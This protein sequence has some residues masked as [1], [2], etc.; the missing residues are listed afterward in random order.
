MSR[1][2]LIG[3]G[4]GS[5]L[6]LIGAACTPPQPNVGTSEIQELVAPNTEAG[7]V[8]NLELGQSATGRLAGTGESPDASYHTYTI[9][10]PA[11]TS[12]L[13]IRMDADDDL[14][15]GIKHGSPIEAYGENADWDLNDTSTNTFATLTV[16][17]PSA[18]VWYVDVINLLTSTEPI[19]YRLETE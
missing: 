3:F 5:A 19:T 16:N 1:H 15:L 8:G 6:L 11:G 9:D 13:V 17:N 18:G 14:D 12:Q 7:T 4:V 2:Q 10:V